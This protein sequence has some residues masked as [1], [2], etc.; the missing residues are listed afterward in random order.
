MKPLSLAPAKGNRSPGSPPTVP[1]PIEMTN[2]HRAYGEQK[3][4][5][6]LDLRIRPGEVFAL[7]GR[8]GAGKTTALRVLLGFLKPMAGQAKLLGTSSQEL[9]PAL[10]ERIGFVSENHRLEHERTVER[11]LRFE[12]LT[13]T[14][15]DH[16]RALAKA[17]RLGLPLNRKVEKL[18]R[19]QRAQ[20]ALLVAL[21]D[22][23]EVLLFDDPGLGL[24]VA[25]RRELLDALI[26]LLSDAGSTVLF[27]THV[28]SDVERLAD[29]VGILHEGRLTV[30][31]TREDLRARVQQ[32]FIAGDVVPPEIPGLLSS[33][34]V[35]GGHE[36]T[37][38][39]SNEQELSQLD[40]KFQGDSVTPSL[41]DLFLALTQS[42]EPAADAEREEAKS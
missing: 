20:L 3:I 23:P 36:V 19:G 42:T 22:N 9:A 7:L 25:M 27:T 37:L 2:I 15:F 31:A 40:V 17:K 11:T 12:Q 13:R 41:E 14:R 4:L 35:S 30:D 21:S 34:R 6:G 39:D 16:S 26:D 8:N 18:S 10:R 33:R 38:L 32:R 29:R 1:F 28:M 24:D 5:R